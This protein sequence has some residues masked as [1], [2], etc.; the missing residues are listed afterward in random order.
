MH[1]KIFVRPIE[2]IVVKNP[3]TGLILPADSTTAVEPN[4]FWLRRI[5]QG[6]VEVVEHVEKCVE[7]SE[8][9]KPKKVSKKKSDSKKS[10]EDTSGE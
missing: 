4:Q 3:R 6:D 9:E 1:D 10:H 7:K 5:E 8:S 2:G